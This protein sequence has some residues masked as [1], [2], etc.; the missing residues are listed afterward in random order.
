[1]Q[2]LESVTA[3][4]PLTSACLTAVLGVAVVTDLRSHK[5][6]NMLVVTGAVVALA[7]Q[8]G[9]HGAGHGVW[10][11]ATGLAAG[12]APFALLYVMRAVGAGDAKLMGCIGAF[13]GPAA[14]PEILLATLLAGGALALGVML[15][16][17]ESRRTLHAVLGTVLW[18]PF[19]G[20]A[21]APTAA[22][23]AAPAS[24]SRIRTARRLP[25]AVAIATGVG[26]V[27]A[28]VL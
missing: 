27:M 25:Y 16:R 3:F 9:L 18:M 6:P 21:P 14:M 24:A 1:M 13:T 5:I 22:P 2:T 26:L 28:G 11:W 17:G 19:A 10:Q 4:Y 23:D 8:M 12:L 15:W 7:L 20:H